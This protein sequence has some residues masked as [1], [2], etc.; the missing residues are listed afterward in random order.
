MARRI[1]ITASARIF[2]GSQLLSATP[3]RAHPGAGI[4]GGTIALA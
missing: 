2:R 4:A 1:E 3:L